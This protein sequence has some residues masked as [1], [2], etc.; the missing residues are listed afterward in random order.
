MTHFDRTK[1]RFLRLA[2]TGTV[3]GL[4]GCLGGDDG[5]AETTTT[6]ATTETGDDD[7]EEELPEGV[8]REEFERG[9]V[10]DAYR[11]ARSQADEERNPDELF[12]KADVKFQEA[13][14]AV[15]AG[16]TQSGRDCDNCAEY[17]PDKNGDGF[18][19][20]ARVEGYIGPEDWCSL[21]ESIEE[22]EAE[23]EAGEANN[24]S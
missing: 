6:T 4:A 13:T 9:P 20:C 8:S 12:P 24:S 2:G 3:V 15:E 19:A 23:A 18:G 14:D 21:W 7:H 1:R 17:I 16:L 22:A 11:T 10:P 5:Q